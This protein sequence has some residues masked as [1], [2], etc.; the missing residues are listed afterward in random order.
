MRAA[1]DDQNIFARILRGEIPS[2]RVA[3]NDHAIA[4]RDIRPQAQVHLLVIPK[5][6]YVSYD[7]F[8]ANASD[9][10]IVGFN[11]LVAEVARA[12]GL[13]LADGGD[14]FRAITNAGAH[15]VQEVPHFHLHLLGGRPMGRMVSRD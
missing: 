1:Y 5:G 14:G 15:G 2:D 13:S 6:A 3:E 4:F 8:A 9:D 7:D 12:E 10:E 11:R